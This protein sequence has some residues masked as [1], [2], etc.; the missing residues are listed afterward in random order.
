MT[1][2]DLDL[3]T[4]TVLAEAGS[5]GLSGMVGVANVLKNR[6]GTG[7][8]GDSL[9]SVT[10]AK[11]QFEPMAH[12]G[13]GTNNDPARFSPTSPEY[14]QAQRIVS[15]VM[16]G[17]V[18][19][20]TRGATHFYSPSGQAALGRTPPEWAQGKPTAMIGGHM[21]YNPDGTP[22]TGATPQPQISIGGAPTT[23]AD[24]P[25]AAINSAG[26]ASLAPQ[27]A[28]PA[29]PAGGGMGVPAHPSTSSP[30]IAFGQGL[31]GNMLGGHGMGGAAPAGAAAGAAPPQ[32]GIL[33][34]MLFGDG[35][36]KGAL[37][38]IPTPNGGQGLFGGLFPHN[39][40][41]PSPPGAPISMGN[42]PAP[43]ISMGAPPAPAP[44][45]A[46]AAPGPQAA[47]GAPQ[48]LGS[49]FSGLQGLFG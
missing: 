23:P 4:R 1:P 13:T 11:N 27:P 41:L 25:L 31:F 38:G 49:L 44:A 12:W 37:G 45:P 5:Q 30:A 14:Q 42:T 6:V 10:T 19:D 18:P 7:R 29:A 17:Q 2:Q 16:A 24:N 22:S 46:P 9:S 21:F 28:A 40:P 15:A 3:A 39:P 35:G 36:L 33:G 20:L 26:P 32:A 8:W 34:R 43:G 48:G 47:A